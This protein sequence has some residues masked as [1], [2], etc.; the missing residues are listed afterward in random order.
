MEKDVTEFDFKLKEK[1]NIIK[2]ME[3][4]REK[5][6]EIDNAEALRLQTLELKNSI[7][8]QS[9]EKLKEIEERLKLLTEKESSE[10]KEQLKEKEMNYA[11]LE[12]KYKKLEEELNEMNK[13]MTKVPEEIK[14]REDSIEYY[15]NQLE[16]KEKT[17]NEEIRILSSL[18]HKLSYRFAKTKSITAQPNYD[19]INL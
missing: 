19:N 11:K 18:Y 7:N 12:E 13:A 3:T 17:H 15:K 14:K 6:K 8:S 16:F 1:E 9:N 10:L 2:K 4:E 5:K